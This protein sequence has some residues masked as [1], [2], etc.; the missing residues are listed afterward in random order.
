MWG[1]RG[2]EVTKKALDA[3]KA[4]DDQKK[5]VKALMEKN[6]KN[7][8]EFME[9]TLK[10]KMPEP[11]KAPQGGGQRPQLTDEQRTKF[12][13]FS[14]KQ[15]SATNAELK[16]ILGDKFPAFEKAMKAEME[17]MRQSFGGPGGRPGQGGPGKPGQGGSRKPPM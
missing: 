17:K 4:T 14:T 9:K 7:S 12:R 1:R 16:K 13:E 8:R 10:I 6:A 5:K 2:E 11:G 3:A 15:M